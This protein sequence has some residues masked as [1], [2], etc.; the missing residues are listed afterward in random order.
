MSDE[1][2]KIYS[3]ENDL[4]NVDNTTED[5]FIAKLE[6]AILKSGYTERQIIKMNARQGKTDES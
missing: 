6:M 4:E 3:M 1:D 5:I 2:L